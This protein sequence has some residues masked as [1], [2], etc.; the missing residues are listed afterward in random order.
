MDDRFAIVVNS[1]ELLNK[2]SC[3]VI[4]KGG[5]L[6]TIVKAVWDTGAT[7]TCISP[8][9]ANELKLQKV[10]EAAVTSASHTV[11]RT[12]IYKVDIIVSDDIRFNDVCVCEMNIQY[13]QIGMLIGMDLISQGDFATSN[14]NGQTTFT[15]RKPSKSKIE[16]TSHEQS[17]IE[18]VELAKKI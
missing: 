10:G 4:V 17:F 5:Q 7:C 12:N 15:F 16:F 2:L 3:P 8:T 6:K 13:Q 18:L 1:P 11:D 14:F 9:L